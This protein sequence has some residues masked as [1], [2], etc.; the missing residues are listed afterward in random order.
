MSRNSCQASKADSMSSRIRGSRIRLALMAL[1]LASS[2]AFAQFQGV[3]EMKMNIAGRDGMAGDGTMKIAVGEAGSRSDMNLHMPQMDMKLSV[4]F[5]NDTPDKV[6]HLNEANKTYAVIDLAKAREMAGKY[7]D[8]TKYTVQ[9]LGEETILGYLTQHVLVTHQ[10][11]TNEMWTTK[12]LFDYATFSR[13]QVRQ[14]G[15]AGSGEGMIK[16][17]KDAGVDGVP[18]K[19][20]AHTEDGGT[21]TIEVT[22]IAK[23]ALPSSTFELPA[24]YTQSRGGMM[25]VMGGMSGPKADEAKNEAKK[26]LDEA[27]KN[28]TPE[29]REMMEKMMK[30]QGQGGK[31]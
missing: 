5:K 19:S 30:S 11:A 28:L 7:Q 1:L 24:D 22:K 10:N 18:L 17:L 14:G 21:A 23:T 12:D 9:K 31:E 4:L 29:Q 16:A 2:T 27:L 20:I 25:D 6:Y 26:K 3:V 13:M 15:R 8:K